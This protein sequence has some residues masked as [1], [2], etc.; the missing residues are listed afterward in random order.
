MHRRSLLAVLSM[1]PA[2]MML[3]QVN[4]SYPKPRERSL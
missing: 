1:G 3:A 4:S 2:V